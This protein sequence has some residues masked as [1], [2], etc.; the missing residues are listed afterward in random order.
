MDGWNTTFLLGWL[1]FRCHVS[2]R[3]G[4]RFFHPP[5]LFTKVAFFVLK[6]LHLKTQIWGL[7]LCFVMRKMDDYSFIGQPGFP[8]NKRN[9]Q[10]KISY[11][12]WLKN[13]KCVMYCQ[14]PVPVSTKTF[15]WKS[16][17]SLLLLM[18]EIPNNHLGCMKVWNPKNN[19]KKNNY[20]PQVVIAGFQPSTVVGA[21]LQLDQKY[22]TL[23]LSFLC[24]RERICGTNCRHVF[25]QGH[26]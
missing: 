12:F 13:D 19:G 1:I 10:K 20:L 2:F 16:F 4:S 6:V 5:G 25:C 14:T 17:G 24:A 7:N 15:C 23:T 21:S 3:E 26:K 22:G 11:P 8:W 9:V 18:A